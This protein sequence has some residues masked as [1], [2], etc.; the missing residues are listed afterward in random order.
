MIRT[1]TTATVST[2]SPQDQPHCSETGIRRAVQI[3]RRTD[4]HK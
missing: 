4:Q 2:I 1:E 3:D